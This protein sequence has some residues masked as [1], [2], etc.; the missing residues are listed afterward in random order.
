MEG[1]KEHL[2]LKKEI[3]IKKDVWERMLQHC[4]KE[5]PLEACGI[6]SGEAG[7]CEK[8]WEMQNIARSSYSFEMSQVELENTLQKIERAKGQTLTGIYHSHPTA[9]PIP[10]QQDIENAHYHEAVYFIISLSKKYP[11]VKCYQII[12]KKCLPVRLKIFND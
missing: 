10:S 1:K 7:K 11:R 8:I 3:L 6:L 2:G 12:G 5:K 4:M 9:E